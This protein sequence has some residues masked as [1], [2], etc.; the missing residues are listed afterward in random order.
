VAGGYAVKQRAVFDKLNLLRSFYVWREWA[1]KERRLQYLGVRLQQWYVRRWLLGR[2]WDRWLGQARL[3]Y[4]TLVAERSEKQQ[5]ADAAAL[6]A[7]HAQEAGALR[8]AQTVC[9]CR[10]SSA[11]N[12]SCLC[13]QPRTEV[14]QA[15]GARCAHDHACHATKAT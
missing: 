9:E 8:Y 12:D 13:C 10:R 7:T 15:A 4:R 14:Q 6:H 3:Q 2:A 11:N 1:H 5:K